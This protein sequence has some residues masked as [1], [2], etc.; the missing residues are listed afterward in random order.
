MDELV[1]LNQFLLG[2]A[3]GGSS[4]SETSYWTSDGP[5]D[6]AVFLWLEDGSATFMVEDQI[7]E[8]TVRAYFLF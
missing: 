2:R 5:D 3:A 6:K 4:L 1:L 8:Y 7:Y